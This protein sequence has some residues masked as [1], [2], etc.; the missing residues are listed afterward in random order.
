MA[1]AP[2]RV[3][4]L[5]ALTGIVLLATGCAATSSGSHARAGAGTV[6]NAET[7]STPSL[8][9]TSN[10]LVLPLTPYYPSAQQ[11]ASMETVRSALIARCA[12][13]AGFSRPAII[14][15][16]VQWGRDPGRGQFYD[17]GVTNM[18]FA[19][20]YGYHDTSMTDPWRTATGAPLPSRRSTSKAE[21]LALHSCA[22]KVDRSTGYL[23]SNW[24]NLVQDLAIQA[25]QD[26]KTSPSMLS[27]FRE[28]SSC[29]AA[30]G[31]R[32]STPLAALI[33]Q[34]GN[35]GAINGWNTAAP[36]QLE[37]QTATT[38]VA[39]KEKTGLIKTWISVLV[40]DQNALLRTNLPQLRANMTKFQSIYHKEQQLLAKG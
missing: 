31:F 28:W 37:I 40:A 13:Q 22:D 6:G 2:T 34:Q 35:S 30:K 14:F 24:S 38:D 4:L 12:Q 7:S 23:N 17:F 32:Y 20:R 11:M 39:C 21:K 25:G 36:T 26:A 5:A 29:M 18:A 8:G 9:E 15:G 1:F 19:E 16:A 3:M 27:Q 10:S 33:G